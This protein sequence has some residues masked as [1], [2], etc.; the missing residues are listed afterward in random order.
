MT[1]APGTPT[2]EGEQPEGVGPDAGRT[3]GDAAGH[4]EGDAGAGWA[5]PAA[6]SS[7]A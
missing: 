4:V 5:A 7:A 3:A 1:Q 6:A 2:P